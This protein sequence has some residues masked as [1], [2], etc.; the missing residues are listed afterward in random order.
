MRD[1]VCFG[2]KVSVSEVIRVDPCGI[3]RSVATLIGIKPRL[4]IIG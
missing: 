1:M 3:L 4:A 2:S